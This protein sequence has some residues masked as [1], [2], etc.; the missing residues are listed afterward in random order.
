MTIHSLWHRHEDLKRQYCDYISDQQH[1]D[2]HEH[3]IDR[4]KF[5]ER[6]VMNIEFG[7]EIGPIETYR[8]RQY[9]DEVRRRMWVIYMAGGYATYY[10]SLTA[11]DVISHE[12][13]PPG[14][15]Y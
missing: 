11:W 4:R 9:P 15:S 12:I 10:Y 13:I 7:Y 14:Y 2:W 1:R 3:I 6:P 5:L 8:V